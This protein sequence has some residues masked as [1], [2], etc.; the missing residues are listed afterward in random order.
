MHKAPMVISATLL[1]GSHAAITSYASA[2]GDSTAYVSTAGRFRNW[3]RS[4]NRRYSSLAG[5]IACAL[6]ILDAGTAH[7]RL[8]HHHYAPTHHRHYADTHHRHYGDTHHHDHHSVIQTGTASFY[9]KRHQGRRTASGQ[10]FD[11]R[12]LT[13]A[14]PWLPLGSK[15]RVTLLGT[16]RSVVVKINDRMPARRRIVDLSLAAARQLGMMHAGVA[17][18]RLTPPR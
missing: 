6:L 17:R 18:V 9:G 5:L 2:A 7:A 16:G 1:V 14:H 11:D 10:R 15:V 3:K 12:L 8:H 4:R 13:A